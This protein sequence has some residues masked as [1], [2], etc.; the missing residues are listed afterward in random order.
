MKNGKQEKGRNVL[1]SAVIVGRWWRWI[2]L[3]FL[4]LAGAFA[5]P[6]QDDQVPPDVVKFKTLVK[7]DGTNGGNPSSNAQP[8]LAQMEIS[9]DTPG[10]RVVATFGP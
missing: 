1:A 9:T 7:F 3:L 2:S 10:G 4:V 8:P 6:A 5:S